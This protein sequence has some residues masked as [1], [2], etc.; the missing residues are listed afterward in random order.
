MG[1]I[2]PMRADLPSGTVTFL[3]TDVE[4]STRLLEQLGAEAYSAALTEHRRVIREACSSF[5]GVEVDTQGDAFLVAFTSAPEAIEAA[6]TIRDRLAPGPIS[7]RMGLHT[8]APLLTEEGYVG[9]DVHRAARIAAA[10]HGG[11]V[12]VSA[13]AAALVDLELRDLGEHRFRDLAAPEHVFQVGVGE[14]PPLRTLYHARL[15]VP[16]TS[17]LGREAELESVVEFL[18]RDD[19]SLLTLV[20]PGG[21]GKTRLALQ[22]AGRASDAYDGVWWVPLAPLDHHADLLSGVAQALGLKEQQGRPLPETLAARLTG[23]RSL[24]LLDNAEHLLPEAAPAIAALA[25][26]PG[27][28]LLVTSRERL[29]LQGEQVF[30]VPTLTEEEGIELFVARARALDPGFEADG[31]VAEVCARLDN[32]PLAIELAAARTMLFSPE[33]LLERLSQR[34]D[35]LRGGRDAEPRQQTLRATIGWSYDLLAPD[36]QRLFR[37]LSAFADCSFEAAEQVCGADPDTLQSLLDKSLL[38]RRGSES[39]IRYAM[40]ETIREYASER[41]EESGEATEVRRRHAEWCCEL[42]ERAVGVPSAWQAA[43]FEGFEADY[44]NVRSAL[45]WAWRSGHDEQGLRLGATLGFW[46]KEGLFH[47]AVSWLDAA[48]PRIELG[49]PPAQLTARK[50]AGLIAFFLLA[51]P[52]EADAHWERGLAVAEQ[53]GDTDEVE[54]LEDRRVSVDWERGKLRAG[55]R[56]FRAAGGAYRKRGDRHGEA[57]ALHLLGELER[58][59]GRFDEAEA[60]LDEADGAYLELGQEAGYLNNTHSRADLALDRGDLDAAMDRYR[61]A[62]ALA[63]KLGLERTIT[64]CLA[65]IASVLAERGEDDTAASIWGAV[66]AAEERLGFRMIP[67][68]RHRYE[69]RTARLESTAAWTAGKELTLDEAVASIPTR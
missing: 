12:L 39:V 59:L 50:A 19:L 55:R 45:A 8:G 52:E 62:L 24:L 49:S 51:D 53:L 27:V 22:G 38:R 69:R 48:R 66:G 33:H 14:Y 42:A 21:T 1:M 36:E 4:G 20:G 37:S 31:S 30:P 9:T 6:C 10:G 61:A 54:W 47:D 56:A 65:G 32:L 5:G 16:T 13:A 44:D 60:M 29:Q 68:E 34:L 25:A 67:M 40:L 41:L 11:Q 64:Y 15:P 35:L 3:F 28:T 63:R 17:F 46:I 58:D 18:G 23:G 2:R 7:V 57:R 43:E 26:V